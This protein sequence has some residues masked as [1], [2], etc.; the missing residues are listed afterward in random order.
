MM[1]TPIGMLATPASL[2]QRGDLLGVALHQAERRIDGAAQADQAG[3][4]VLRLEPRRVELVMH[5][6]RAEV[7]Q[8]R[9]AAAAREQRPAGELV[10]LPLADLGRGDVADVVDVEHQQRAEVG[11]LQ[12]LLDA[13]RAGSGAGGGNRRA[14]RNRRPWCRAPAARGPSCSAG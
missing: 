6:G 8:D 2:D 14:P 4:A 10:A 13:R 1:S 5:G 9:L 12:R 3:L 7:P 11:L